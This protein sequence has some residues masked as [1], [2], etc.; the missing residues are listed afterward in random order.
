M[1]S[2]THDEPFDAQPTNSKSF[3][4]RFGHSLGKLFLATK[5]KAR[6]QYRKVTSG[7]N[8]SL[9]E[10]EAL[11]FFEVQMALDA[12]AEEYEQQLSQERKRWVKKSFLFCFV[13]LLLGGAT[14]IGLLYYHVMP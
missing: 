12:Q 14:A 8:Q 6:D 1:M 10:E 3:A 2:S 5:N 13:A 7:I 11:R 9:E 4:N